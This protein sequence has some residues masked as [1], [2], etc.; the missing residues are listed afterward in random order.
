MLNLGIRSPWIPKLLDA[1]KSGK[2]SY[3]QSDFEDSHGWFNYHYVKMKYH[4]LKGGKYNRNAI[5]HGQKAMVLYDSA[6]FMCET[7]PDNNEGKLK[8]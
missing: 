6:T 1:F 8:T 3:S 7:D 5:T 4:F 2:E